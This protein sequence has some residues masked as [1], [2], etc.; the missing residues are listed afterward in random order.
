MKKLLAVPIE[1]IRKIER[2]D[3]ECRNAHDA[4]YSPEKLEE[5][6]LHT[7][8]VASASVHIR[9]RGAGKRLGKV[10]GFGVDSPATSEDLDEIL[11]R[12]RSEKVSLVRFRVPPTPQHEEISDWLVEKG[13]KRLTFVVQWLSELD[14]LRPVESPFPIRTVPNS[15][16]EALGQLIATNYR[17]KDTDSASYHARLGEIPGMQ[18]YMA[19]DGEVPI[20]TGALY[21]LGEGCILQYGTTQGAYR[22]RGIQTA[23]IGYRSNQAK[24][25]GCQWAC[26][27]TMTCDRSG[28]NMQKQGFDRAYDEQVYACEWK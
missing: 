15:E 7:F 28:R 21:R 10:Y 11:D 3:R 18:C 14:S 8:R 5:K 9:G 6:G 2:I 23:M 4:L 26:A 22:K 27:S 12:L 13:L 16:S 19:F 1:T 20:A 17:L 24:S 25:M